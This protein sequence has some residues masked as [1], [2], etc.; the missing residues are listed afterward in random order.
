[1]ELPDMARTAMGK[2]TSWRGQQFV[3]LLGRGREVLKTH[4]RVDLSLVL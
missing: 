3:L 1:M 4:V 2:M